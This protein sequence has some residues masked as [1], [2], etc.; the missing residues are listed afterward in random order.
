MLT[1]EGVLQA[2]T[3]DAAQGKFYWRHTLGRKREGMEA[4]S[5]N[6]AG[7]HIVGICGQKIMAHRLVWLVEHG[8]FPTGEIDHINRIP[9]DNR[10]ENLRLANRYLN[11]R[12]RGMQRNNRLGLRGVV[13]RPDGYRARI[14]HHGKSIELGVFSTA[15]EAAIAYSAAEKVCEIFCQVGI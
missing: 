5:L 14:R 11:M 6:P 2:L 4:G 13:E 3:Y 1:R 10:I 8:S 15:K 12:N 9:N 7:Y